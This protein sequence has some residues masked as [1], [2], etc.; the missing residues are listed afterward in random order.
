[1]R[2]AWHLALPT[3]GQLVTPAVNLL[4]AALTAG[5]PQVELGPATDA[6][7]LRAMAQSGDLTR[8]DGS[9]L[10]VYASVVPDL[11]HNKNALPGSDIINAGSGTDVV[12][13]DYGLIGALPTTGVA[14]IDTQLQG[15]SVSMLGLI[16]GFSALSTAQ[17]ALENSLGTPTRPFTISAG[18]DTITGSGTETIFGGG[19]EYLVPGVSFP[20]DPASASG[21]AL[22]FDSY[23]LD[24]Q[25]VVGDMS[26]VTHEAGEQVISAFATADRLLR[27]GLGP[28][29]PRHPSAEP[30]QQHHRPERQ[31]RQQSRGRRHRLRG[32]AGG[33]DAGRVR[34]E[35]RCRRA[36]RSSSP[37][38]RRRSRRI[39]PP[40]IRSRPTMARRR[41]G[42]SVKRP[43][44]RSISATITS[45][46]APG[47]DTLIGDNA[48]IL[49][50]VSETASPGGSASSVQAIMVTAVDRLFLGAYSAL[51]RD[52]RGL[53]G[54]GDAGAQRGGRLVP[55]RRLRLP[56]PALRSTATPSM[57]V[58]ATTTSIGDMAVILPQL[59]A[60]GIGTVGTFERLSVERARRHAGGR[61]TTTSTA[62][63]RSGR[64]I[65]GARRPRRRRSRSTPTR[66]GAATATTSC[67]A[68]SATTT[69]TAAPVTTSCPAASETIPFPAGPAPIRSRSIA[70]ATRISAAAATTSRARPS[71][72]RPAARFCRSAGNP[73]SDRPSAMA[74]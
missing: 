21:N 19:G 48:L 47:A 46:A 25:Q 18:N 29:A 28:A 39:S 55:G 45:P 4:P 15:L 26:F 44:S 71:T 5:M 32:H 3:N 2:P 54:A 50:P 62:S 27:L 9:T 58:P 30:R 1:M 51:E 34:R 59:A 57:A 7:S 52:Q 35:R 14:A 64:C 17:D 66:S 68:R 74:C 11:I 24:M 33:C 12:F 22:A 65:R 6:G 23:L 49:D 69:S 43:V 73:R 38:A 72:S 36:W 20:M 37:P 53:R 40:I 10:Q 63:G 67:S 31:L 41:N 61:T 16:D 13:G 8:I 60:A 56:Q 42:C 70:R